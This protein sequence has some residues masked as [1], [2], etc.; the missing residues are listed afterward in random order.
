MKTL[1]FTL[2]NHPDRSALYR[3]SK[4]FRFDETLACLCVFDPAII[5]EVFRSDRFNVISFAEQYRYITE[6]TST[7]FRGHRDGL[8][9]CA[10]GQ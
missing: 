8:R 4:P 3:E 2:H 10:A 6:Q 1:T 9:P 7:G 5:A